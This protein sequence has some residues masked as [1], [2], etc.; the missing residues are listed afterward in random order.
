V[1]ADEPTHKVKRITIERLDDDDGRAPEP[2]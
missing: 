2:A 1:L